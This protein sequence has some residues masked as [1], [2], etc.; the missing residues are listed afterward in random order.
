MGAASEPSMMHNMPAG[1]C[2]FDWPRKLVCKGANVACHSSQSQLN[3]EPARRPNMRH[4]TIRRP[5]MSAS[6][7]PASL[8]AYR[9]AVVVREPLV[10]PRVAVATNTTAGG[11]PRHEHQAKMGYRSNLKAGKQS[12]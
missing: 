4:N 9:K 3:I 5:Q 1:L 10:A 7:G 8:L 11:A 2:G 12:L 6:T